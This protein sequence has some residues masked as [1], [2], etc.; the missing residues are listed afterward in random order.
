[1]TPDHQMIG[2]SNYAN[3]VWILK[4]NSNSS[5]YEISQIISYE[6]IGQRILSITE[7]F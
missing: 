2:V 6:S 7:D 3:S 5:Q 1:M 4:F